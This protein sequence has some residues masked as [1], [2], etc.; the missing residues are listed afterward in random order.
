MLSA[1]GLAQQQPNIDTTSVENFDCPAPTRSQMIGVCNCIYTQE[2]GSEEL[3][4][5]YKYQEELWELS[6]ADPK[7]DSPEVAHQKIRE[8]WD[9]NKELFRCYKYLGVTVPDGNI[10]KFSMDTGFSSFLVMA[11]KKYKLDVNFIDPADG[12][13]IMD[14]LKERLNNYKSANYP[15]KCAEYKRIYKLYKEYGAKHAS[16]L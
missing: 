4:I 16:E 9:K 3:G 7:T 8:M 2:V 6:C 5:G 11:V 12:K 15:E 1:I 14:F 13:T 10:L